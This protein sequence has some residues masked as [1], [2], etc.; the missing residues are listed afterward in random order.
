MFTAFHTESLAHVLDELITSGL[1]YERDKGKGKFASGQTP[2]T[3]IRKARRRNE[4]LDCSGFVRYVLF[5]ATLGRLHLTGG[6]ESQLKAV[7]A[8]GYKLYEPTDFAAQ[9]RRV[10][11]VLRIGFLDTHRG[12]NAAGET[13]KTRVGH[14]WLTLNGYTYESSSSGHGPSVRAPGRQHARPDN[15]AELG[16]VPGFSRL[17]LGGLVLGHNMAVEMLE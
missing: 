8:A 15:L 17:T 12:T 13:V 9:Q 10:D 6:S 16:P 14:V 5:R 7:K 3:A 11:D 4:G 1:P 2:D